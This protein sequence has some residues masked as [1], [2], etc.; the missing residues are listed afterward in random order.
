MA[1]N[2]LTLTWMNQAK[3]LLSDG[4]GGYEWVERDD[5]RVTEVRLLDLAHTAGNAKGTPADNLL[6]LGDA[7][8]ALRALNRIPEYSAQY[9]GKVKLVYIDPPFN[10]GQAFEQYDDNFEHSVWLTMFRD[11]IRELAR[12]MAD[13]G[14]IWV[15][16]DDTEV[17]RARQVLDGEF[18]INSYLGTVIW[19]KADSPRSDLPN[20]SSDHD[21]LLV[22]GK[23]PRARLNRS[24]RDEALN[25][26]YKSPD[27]DPKPWFDG[28][29]TA[30]SAHRN[31]TWVYAVQSPI[32]GDLM[33]PAKGRCWATKQ[34][35]VLAAMSEWAPYE[36]RVLDDDAKR[37]EICGV[38]VEDLRKGIP[39]LMLAVPLDEA[40]QYAEERKQAGI[41]PE[42]ILRSRG[43]LGRKRPQPD[44]GSNTRTMWFN[45]EVGHNREAKAEIKALFPGTTA[46][47]TPKPE[48]FLKKI[49]EVSTQPNDIVVDCFAGSGTTAAVAHKL[50]RRWVTIEAVDATV[51]DFTNPRLTQV[52]EGEQ[53]GVSIVKSRQAPF[54]L[55][56]GVTLSALD[57]A[58]KV[59]QKLLDSDGLDVDR[60]LVTELLTQMRTTP[61]KQQI[62]S[63]GGG[64]SALSV[65]PPCLQVESGFA[66]LRDVDSVTF[67]RYVAAQLGYTLTGR[68]GLTAVK[69]RDALV[70][71]AG[72]V[73][74]EIIHHSIT[75][76]DESE[77][78]TLAG[79]AVHPASVT[80]LASLRPGSRVMKVPD[81]LIKRSKVVR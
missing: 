4:K 55:P 15:H 48:R 31:Q 45:T 35:S 63:G 46:F 26:I 33:Y 7:Y 8:D 36:L 6:I 34:E 30:P 42:Y 67:S 77:T 53:G 13:D 68:R 50:G 58:R 56:A 16:L 51:K 22:Y 78:V 27:G 41:W 37:A 61:V 47:A 70:V 14:I 80:T 5:P 10:T 2:R 81:A 3:T 1:A 75:L 18:G 66:F 59:V 74:D 20:F 25:S 9:R 28:D 29:P 17:H 12:L 40:R 64:F 62:W 65:A 72:M 79:T 76:L 11:R 57:D 39:A 19:Q 32:T 23:T 38:P 73:D 54:D 60:D 44:T 69:G 49:I 71:I 21:T 43:T 24:E 52:V